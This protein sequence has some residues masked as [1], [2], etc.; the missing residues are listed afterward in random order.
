MPTNIMI[1]FRRNTIL[2]KEIKIKLVFKEPLIEEAFY[3]E[4]LMPQG[5]LIDKT[6]KSDNLVYIKVPPRIK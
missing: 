4:D 6:A 5:N 1:S 3:V 2:V